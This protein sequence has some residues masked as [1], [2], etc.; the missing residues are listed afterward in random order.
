MIDVARHFM[1]KHD[2][3]RFIDLMAMHRLNVLHLHLTDDQGWRVEIR[4][5]PRLTEAG[6][7]RRERQ[8]GAQH[9]APGAGRPPGGSSQQGVLRDVVGRRSGGVRTVDAPSV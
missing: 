6:A 8:H 9:D 3:L 4:R 5:Y 7:W 1:P 2:V